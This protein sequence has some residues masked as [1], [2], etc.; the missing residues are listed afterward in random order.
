M[1]EDWKSWFDRHI[2]ENGW[3]VLD[4]TLQV[5]QEAYRLPGTFHADPADRIIVA[6][7]RIH[8][9][10][11]LTADQKIRKYRHVRTIW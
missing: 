5:I 2:Q 10:A 11:L 4:I 8:D 6:T 3:T 7:S 9:M 1:E